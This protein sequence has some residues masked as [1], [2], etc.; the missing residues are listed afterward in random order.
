MTDR[1]EIE[2]QI[3]TVDGIRY[4]METQEQRKVWRTARREYRIKLRKKRDILITAGALCGYGLTN[5]GPCCEPAIDG[6]CKRHAGIVCTDC[7]KMAVGECDHIGMLMCGFPI[8]K[9]CGHP[10]RGKRKRK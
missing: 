1:D 7:D 3:A 6:R 2:E 5:H 8:C 10:H 9:D 4:P